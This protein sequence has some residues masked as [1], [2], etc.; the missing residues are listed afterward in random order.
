MPLAVWM[1][2]PAAWIQAKPTGSL[3]R[4]NWGVQSGE[5]R[6]LRQSDKGWRSV[7][8]GRGGAPHRH[9]CTHTLWTYVWTEPL[10][11]L[12]TMLVL[13]SAVNQT[14]IHLVSWTQEATRAKWTN[15]Q[16]ELRKCGGGNE[17][18]LQEW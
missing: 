10:L 13:G 15:N 14:N 6:G 3:F 8:A 7:W 17:Q 11:V 18:G 4:T 12:H 9:P 1:T 5:D 2:K 16:T